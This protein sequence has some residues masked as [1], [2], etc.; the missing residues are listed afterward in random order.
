MNAKDI[1]SG[2]F[3]NGGSWKIT[4]Q[5]ELYV[6]AVTVPDF[7]QSTSQGTNAPWIPYKGRIKSIRFSSRVQ[8]IGKNAFAFLPHVQKVTFDNHASANVSIGTSAFSNCLSLRKFDFSYVQ[9]IGSYAFNR[10]NFNFVKLP[11]VTKI[12]DYAFAYNAKMMIAENNFNP[13]IVIT[14]TIRP[15]LSIYSLSHR[16]FSHTYEVD[17]YDGSQKIGTEERIAWN[18]AYYPLYVDANGEIKQSK[19]KI[20]LDRKKYVVVVPVS[21][22][23]NAMKAIEQTMVTAEVKINFVQGSLLAS[24]TSN[25]DI[26]AYWLLATD[27]LIV[28]TGGKPMPDYNSASDVPWNSLRSKIQFADLM[29]TAIGKNALNGCPIRRIDFSSDIK[30][31]HDFAFANCNPTNNSS[32]FR[33]LDLKNITVIGASAFSNSSFFKEVEVVISSIGDAAFSG[34][35][36]EKLNLGKYVTNIGSQAFANGLKNSAHI[37]AYRMAPNTASDAF[38]GVNQGNIRLHVPADLADSYSVAPWSGFYLDRIVE[39][40]VVDEVNHWELTSDG[41]LT[42]TGKW[43]GVE[44]CHY[45][46]DYAQ[47]SDQP[48]YAYR[49]FI[50]KVVFVEDFKHIGKNAFAYESEGE[51][52]IAEVVVPA[53]VETIGENAFK[54]NDQIEEVQAEGVKNIGSQAFENCSALEK[55]KFGKDLSSIGN[56]A[57]NY[58]GLVDVMAVKA[59]VPPTVTAQTFVGLGRVSNN[60]PAK[61]KAKAARR[62]TSATGQK[63][64]NLDVPESSVVTYANTLYWNLFSMDYIGEHGSIEAG[65]VFGNGMWIL[66]ADSTMIISCS[67]LETGSGLQD[68]NTVHDWGTNAGKIK[69]IE[70]LGELTELYRSFNNLPN[71]ESVSFS[72]SV[73]KL[74]ST[75]RNCPKLKEVPLN[76]VEEFREYGSLGCFEQCTSL[77]DVQLANARIIGFR[78]FAECTALKTVE[79]PSVDT[80][81]NVAFVNCPAL[82]SVTVSNAYIGNAFR[83]CTGLKEVT[84]NGVKGHVIPSEAFKGC[85]AL[86]TVRI[87]GSLHSVENDAFNGTALT[88]IYLSSPYPA[89]VAN[90]YNSNVFSGLT[91]S[92]IT[93]HVPA[94]FVNRYNATYNNPVWNRMNVVADED[95]SE[96]LIPVSGPLGSN[97]TWE[98][99]SDQ[100][101]TI[102]CNGAMPTA[103]AATG[104]DSYS[105]TWYDWMP[106]VAHIE[107]TKTTTSVAS[108]AFGLYLGDNNFASVGAI[109]L[110]A[111]M[112]QIDDRGLFLKF[113]NG[114]HVYC[115]AE[116]PPMLNGSNSFNWSEITGKNVTLHVLT[117]SGVLAQYQN[118]AGWQNFPNIVADLGPRY[119]V[120]WDADNGYIKVNESGIDLNAVP[121]GT[122][123]HLTAVPYSGYWLKKWNNYNPSTGLTVSSDVSVSAEFTTNYIVSFYTPSETFAGQYTLLKRDTVEAGQA[124]TAPADPTREGYRFMGWDCS[125]DSIVKQTAVH[126]QFEP[127][128]YAVSVKVSPEVKSVQVPSAELGTKT[129]Q[130]YATVTPGNADNNAVTWSSDDADVATVDANGLVTIH[131]YGA[132]TITATAADGS[133]VS[134]K[135]LLGVFSTDYMPVIQGTAIAVENGIT[136]ITMTKGQSAK[137]VNLVVTP[138]NY[139]G[140]ISVMHHGPLQVNPCGEGEKTLPAFFI[141]PEMGSTYP[142]DDTI[143]FRMNDYDHQAVHSMPVCKLIVHVTDDALF[144]AKTVEGVDMTFRITDPM[145]LTCEVYGYMEQLMMPD[146]V[147][148]L[149]F[150]MH[151]A[152]D[153]STTGKITV[154]AVAKGCTVTNL[155]QQAFAGCSGLTEIELENGIQYIKAGAFQECSAL[156]KLILPK[157]IKGLSMLGSMPQLANVY[158]YN[159]EPP[160]GWE[161]AENGENMMP[162]IAMTNAFQ[163]IA[164]NATLHV[165]RGSLDAYNK[166]PWTTWFATITDDVDATFAVRFVDWDDS[167]IEVQNVDYGASAKYIQAPTRDGHEFTGWDKDFSRITANL[168]VKAQYAALSYTVTF[169]SWDGTQL[170]AAQQVTYGQSAVAPAAPARSGYMFA[171]WSA[172]FSFVTGDMTIKAMYAKEG[173]YLVTFTD[174]DNSTLK[175]EIVDAGGS[176]TAPED[177][178]REGY[179]FAGW[180]GS[181]TNVNA[182]LTIQALYNDATGIEEI[183]TRPDAPAAVK[184]L[185]N[186]ILYIIRPDGKIYTAQGAE[187]R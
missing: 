158:M 137:L 50:K 164:S 18:H 39:F 139:N 2:T 146:P 115:Y 109:T 69:R 182:D 79:F 155:S 187:V 42:V 167:E 162:D 55:V 107:F 149:P 160:I 82:E 186:G 144:T 38:S 184:I 123:I 36:I 57:F 154:P 62:A 9:V 26:P 74:Y 86:E 81:E 134:G 97:G 170:G 118:A 16:D 103:Q 65:D 6:D 168:T 117:K 60:A 27:K 17:I 102:N 108:N 90:Q 12:E 84:L 145:T 174:W 46:D 104:Q 136:E 89:T 15:D 19:E 77:T 59:A 44:K 25:T 135:C 185:H 78:C 41:L 83:G 183:F 106:Y 157:S 14:S 120:S 35:Q 179:I 156:Q 119:K 22:Y 75:F 98:L 32:Y 105:D 1:A 8:T 181:Y 94:D 53:S 128:V 142:Y 166:A 67:S 63:A 21:M 24:V 171:G 5:G 163:M 133:D 23:D 148:G 30:E 64:V 3:K 37:Y 116:N 165:A 96:A 141:K 4:D 85:T 153:A 130:C 34:C 28:Y 45:L 124:A 47:S 112:Q 51:S 176:A 151:P 93:L 76:D 132:A 31:I 110:G 49:T 169:L 113:Q 152:V 92:D 52:Q 58:C 129:F 87:N 180:S 95:Y 40:P 121:E 61:V 138:E 72:S 100:K 172:D 70:V 48:W 71:L 177:P 29:V 140:G 122:T 127:I 54:N 43:N 175:C 7:V 101:L 56:K 178:V 13:S 66:Y 150:V 80:I 10:C 114:G 143:T 91:L 68:Q 20:D 99:G 11:A 73:K 125:F 161:I 147:T 126:A 111:G 159:P 173:Q 33:P 131:N 88:D